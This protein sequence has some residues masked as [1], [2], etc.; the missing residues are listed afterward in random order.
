MTDHKLKIGRERLINL[1]LGKKKCEVRFNDRDYQAEDRLIFHDD[2]AEYYF[3]ITHV[4]SGLGLAEGYVVLSVVKD[5][6][7]NNNV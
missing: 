2:I 3:V 5:V 7:V 6:V 1:V 4:H